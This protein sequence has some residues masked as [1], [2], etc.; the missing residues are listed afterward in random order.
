MKSLLSRK[1]CTDDVPIILEAAEKHL[2]TESCMNALN[3]F[4]QCFYCNYILGLGILTLDLMS[5]TEYQAI[6]FKKLY[7][8]PPHLFTV[9]P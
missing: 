1:K 4:P 9:Q 5:E 3:Y 7:H 6:F 2:L 8:P